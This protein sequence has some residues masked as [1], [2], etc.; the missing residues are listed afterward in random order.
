ME[1][2]PNREEK[3]A[4]T[5][6]LVEANSN[7]GLDLCRRFAKDGKRCNKCKCNTCTMGTRYNWVQINP[8]HWEI[9]GELD[10]RPVA[11][12]IFWARVDG[13]LI[14]FWEVTSQVADYA[15]VRKWQE[16]IFPKVPTVNAMNFHNAIRVIDELKEKE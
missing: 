1:Y 2:I 11:I 4:A 12:T 10:K 3:I 15:M 6:V 13:Y 14:A 9:I 8:G 7:E 5:V 16:K